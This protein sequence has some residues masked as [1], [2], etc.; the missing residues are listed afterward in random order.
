VQYVGE[1]VVPLPKAQKRV[2]ST[3]PVD[4]IDHGLSAAFS[5][6]SADSAAS[7]PKRRCTE[8]ATSAVPV[9]G[10]SKAQHQL[11][12]SMVCGTGHFIAPAAVPVASSAAKQL[13]P[14]A[15]LTG[16]SSIVVYPGI[17]LQQHSTG[18]GTTSPSHPPP[19]FLGVT[20]PP[21]L[22][23]SFAGAPLSAGS[24]SSSI[25]STV[26]VRSLSDSASGDSLQGAVNE[27]AATAA[28]ATAPIVPQHIFGSTV[29]ENSN[30][31]DAGSV[32]GR[33]LKV[34]SSRLDTSGRVSSTTHLQDYYSRQYAIKQEQAFPCHRVIDLSDLHSQPH[35]DQPSGW[36][37]VLCT[38][39]G[40]LRRGMSP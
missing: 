8:V 6:E 22:G 24:E 15:V 18:A 12:P 16:A 26:P 23:T 33:G 5:F 14:G 21:L 30:S 7:E 38:I 32:G 35:E 17:V 4:V 39:A 34:L 1:K 28:H 31:S 9:P 10:Y 36:S 27:I 37:S 2:T 25:T 13:P 11:A 29:W 20:T 40:T 19:P 3:S